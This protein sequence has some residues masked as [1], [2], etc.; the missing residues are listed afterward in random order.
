MGSPHANVDDDNDD[1][2]DDGVVGVVGGDD[3]VVGGDDGV[4]N[5]EKRAM[6]LN[7]STFNDF[8]NYLYDANINVQ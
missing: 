3:G 4:G 2:D 1:N 6:Y 8:Q 7:Q 5:G